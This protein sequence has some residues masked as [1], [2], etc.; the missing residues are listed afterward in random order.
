MKNYLLALTALVAVA[1]VSSE[2]A[3]CR[4][5]L[6]VSSPNAE[7]MV[8]ELPE[9]DVTSCD[10][11]NQCKNRCI[12][13]FN[14]MTNDMDLWS[15]VDGGDTI[16]QYICQNLYHNFLIFI[17]NSYVHAYY[18]M[19]GGPWEYAGLDSQQMLCCNVGQHEHCISR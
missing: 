7:I 10:N 5:G 3:W 16:G 11:H 13:E 8:Y 12:K 17:H 15:T 1:S 19:C 6:F 9:V 2:E 4:C 18:E 14:E